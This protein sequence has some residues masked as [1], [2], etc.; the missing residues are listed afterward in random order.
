MNRTQPHESIVNH[1]HKLQVELE[2]IQYVARKLPPSEFCRD[3][4]EEIH[5][6][7]SSILVALKMDLLTL[8]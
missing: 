4:L 2:H 6:S 8:S 5:Q 3:E 7:I 1:V